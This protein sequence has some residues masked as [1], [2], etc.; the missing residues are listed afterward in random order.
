MDIQKK[1]TLENLLENDKMSNDVGLGS[2]ER[3]LL[4]GVLNKYS[5]PSVGLAAT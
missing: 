1:S 2:Y 4:E 3:N 5:L